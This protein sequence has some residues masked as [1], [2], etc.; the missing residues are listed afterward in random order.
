MSD[1]PHFVVPWLSSDGCGAM[2][3]HRD[4]KAEA[5]VLCR[6]DDRNTGRHAAE[7][8]DG[9]SPHSQDQGACADLKHYCNE[10]SKCEHKTNHDTLL[11]LTNIF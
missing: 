3:S 5:E 4:T 6:D 1:D 7:L 8:A 2:R 11:N 9:D 10:H